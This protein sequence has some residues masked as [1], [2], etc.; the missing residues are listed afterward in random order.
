[1]SSRNST[2]VKL[3]I[4]V[5]YVVL[6]VL[7]GAAAM[8]IL[9]YVDQNQLDD[10]LQRQLKD[11][12]V[13]VNKM[14][15][16]LYR[17][18]NDG[19]LLATGQKSGTEKYEEDVRTVYATLDSLK[20]LASDSVQKARIDSVST[21]FA[22]KGL[23]LKSLVKDADLETYH[24]EVTSRI[25]SLMPDSNDLKRHIVAETRTT[26]HRDTVLT[27][28][29]TGS[30]GKRLRNL[31]RKSRVD[32]T[33]VV[34]EN[35]RTDSV[36]VSLS[37]SINVVLGNL[38]DSVMGVQSEML[39]KQQALWNRISAD[40]YQ[41]NEL[42]Y[43]IILDY[44]R[45]ESASLLKAIRQREQQRLQAMDILAAVAI[46]AI[47]AVLFF[48]F[49]IW[50]DLGRSNRYKRQLEE[51]NE[52]NEAL[53][54]SRE[55]LMLAITHDFKAPL[56]SIIGYTDLLDRITGDKRQK[57]YVGN[58]KSSSQLLLGLVNGLLEFYRL[59]S[60]KEELK[61]VSFSPSELFHTIY[62]TFLPIAHGKGIELKQ[63]VAI[64]DDLEIES[65]P[66][67]LQ[68]V[69]NNLLS[70]AIKFTDNGSVTLS[71]KVEDS[72]LH[73][74]VADTGRGISPL[75]QARL[76]DMFV[77]LSSA[78]GV[79]GFGLGLSIVDR[80]VRLLGGEIRVESALGQ[81]SCFKVDIPVELVATNENSAAEKQSEENENRHKLGGRVLLV[82]DDGLQLSFVSE[83]CKNFG[84]EADTCQ[85][86]EYVERMI[87]KGGYSLVIT[88]I[89]MPGMDGFQVLATVKKSHPDLPVVA[90]TA[91]DVDEDD[92]RKSG[93]SGVLTKPFKERELAAI[94][95]QFLP[96]DVH[97][98]EG[99]ANCNDNPAVRGIDALTAFAG[100]DK[101]A[102]REILESFVTQTEQ[103]LQGLAKAVADGD[104]QTQRALCHKMLPLFTMV[105]DTELAAQLRRHEGDAAEPVNEDDMAFIE[106]RVGDI[107]DQAKTALNER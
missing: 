50:R 3:K 82:D 25:E 106:K 64:S 58:I 72:V 32:S 79:Q 22:V 55:K 60:D 75:E 19:M 96:E 105:G 76:F 38:R 68:Q 78:K 37:D 18:E 104:R 53:L 97:G 73:F 84:V 8:F 39:G 17:T 44:E 41:I 83:L 45:E 65:D 6:L 56:S 21:L 69:V 13:M 14:L 4:L 43:R 42:I 59:D 92:Y 107:I 35:R 67:K 49:I 61:A 95:S 52:A 46:C 15:Y 87:N 93:F 31:F 77:R 11:R 74:A 33:I 85:Y 99:E 30:F 62:A 94:L 100:D 89:Q 9:R 29:S 40:N 63:D 12:S 66:L 57:L 71:A 36:H 26:V 51:A 7:G 86:P 20:R 98:S 34:T 48:V 101:E 88:D 5:A 81:G 28:H 102:C 47:V 24:K 10:R 70:N 27:K 91:R 54:K 80:T 90:V 2:L 23:S 16:Y 103:N 1:M